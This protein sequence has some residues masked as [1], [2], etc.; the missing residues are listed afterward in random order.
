MRLR[1]PRHRLTVLDILAASRTVPA[2]PIHRTFQLASVEH[3]RKGSPVKIGWTALFLKSFAMICTEAPSLRDLFVSYPIR[4]L[5]RHP[6]SVASVSVHRLDANGNER[7]IW[8]QLRNPESLSLIEIQRDL[9]RLVTAPLKEVYKDGLILESFPV[10]L[11]RLAW[12]WGMRWSGRKRAKH[13]G[14]FSISSL[15]GQGCL[16]AYHPLVTSTS[17]AMGPLTERGTMDVVL[18]CDHRMMDGMLGAQALARLEEWLTTE[19]VKE[20]NSSA[21][22]DVL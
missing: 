8:G 9:G 4:H 7:L 10:P 13:V 15:G 19:I 16:N 12:W 3:A 20:L 6:H 1:F 2:F 21:S 14:T 11:R 5:Y 17:L 22:S 18:L